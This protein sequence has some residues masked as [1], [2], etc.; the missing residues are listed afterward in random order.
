[1]S[2]A[3]RTILICLA[4]ALL[5]AVLYL[6]ALGF[7][8]AESDDRDYIVDNYRINHGWSLSGL[9]WCFQ[10][11]YSCNWHPVTWMSH[12]LDCQLYGTNPAGHHGTN[13]LFHAFNAVLV[14]LVLQYLTS[15][16][17]RSAMAAAL[18]AWHPLHVESVAWIAERKDVLSTFLWLLTIWSYAGYAKKLQ[19]Q[20][21]GSIG[22]YS[23]SVLFF[24]LA[25]MAKPMVITLPALLFLLDWWPLR[26]FQSGAS[27]KRLCLEKVP[28]FLLSAYCSAIT[29]VAQN[30]GGAVN[31]MSDAPL[32]FRMYNVVMSYWRYI[33]KLI[34]PINLC[35]L[36]PINPGHRSIL[37]AAFA[38]FA[39]AGISGIVFLLRD[40]KPHWFVGWFWY[41]GT[42]VP[43]IGLVQVGAQTMADRYSYVPA[44]GLFIAVGWTISD[45]A[46]GK[47]SRQIIL[48]VV[49]T[50]TLTACMATTAHQLQY[51]KDGEALYLRALAVTKD[52]YIAHE[53]Y[54]EFL[55]E[56]GRWNEAW[57][58]CQEA[59][60]IWPEFNVIHLWQGI[61][62]Y[63]QGKLDQSEQEIR[64]SLTD[65]W[66]VVG[67]EEYLGR[68]FLKKNRPADAEQA[69]EKEL[70]SNPALP[71][72]HRNLA[73]ALLAQ[74][75]TEQARLEFGEALNLDP[76]DIEARSNLQK[77]I[78]SN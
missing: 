13:I 37:L 1:M 12:M 32:H 9:G 23:A 10:A 68:I 35:Q 36:Y 54:A 39:L 67:G 41:V 76:D 31:T 14:F 61:I 47:R 15:A 28:F 40:S 17:W 16:P 48:A 5:T 62:L 27:F 63:H 2:T 75:K 66:N 59:L 72:A 64:L 30:R 69:F 45:W 7:K 51:W 21:P 43:V 22:C 19:S 65:P 26:R 71:W 11:G 70:S 25:I 3:R 78:R 4:L 42:L 49:A 38:A 46:M 53:G 50:I 58:E 60:Q 56:H 55:V 33:G 18:F 6:P 52:N 8:Y 34:L 73:K 74:G 24:A 57:R 44:L 29:F 77:L 20:K